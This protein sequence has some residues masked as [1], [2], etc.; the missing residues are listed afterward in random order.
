MFY[1]K[2]GKLPTNTI[3]FFKEEILKKKVDN[4]PYQWIQF[5]K[6]LN[7]KFVEIFENTDLK[8]Q[9]SNEKK[10]HTQKAFYSEWGY[11]Y[12]IHKDGLKC[13][14]ALNI[15]ISCNPNDWVRWYDDALIKRIAVLGIKDKDGHEYGYSRDVHIK[16]YEKVPFIEELKVE[17]GDVYLL[18]VDVFH[19]FKCRGNDPRIIIQTKF[20]GYPTLDQIYES[21]KYKSFKNLIT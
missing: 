5:D 3:E 18:N 10:R 7:D 6:T 9:W 8:I 12:G 14:S 2:L 21:L 20:E 17:A 16:Q 11:G 15:A 4:E 19:S 1:R 13:K